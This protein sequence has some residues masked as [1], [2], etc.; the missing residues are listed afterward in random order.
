LPIINNRSSCQ[1]EVECDEVYVVA[2]HK[3]PPAAV[4]KTVKAAI[5]V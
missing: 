4:K 2:D 5:D 1:G 3:G